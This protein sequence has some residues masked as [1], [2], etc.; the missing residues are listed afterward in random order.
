MHERE[1]EDQE[2]NDQID[3][4]WKAIRMGPNSGLNTGEV[5]AFDYK[6]AVKETTNQPG[7]SI[8]ME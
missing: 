5:T 7:L 4:Y 2:G 6:D 8:T 3:A 1:Y